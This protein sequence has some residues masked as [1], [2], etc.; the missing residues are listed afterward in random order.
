MYEKNG[1]PENG[2]SYL[3]DF[4]PCIWL[5]LWI[6]W[7]SIKSSLN[8]TMSKWIHNGYQYSIKL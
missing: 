8:F 3:L 5:W 4:P 1:L 6:C 7:W 2:N